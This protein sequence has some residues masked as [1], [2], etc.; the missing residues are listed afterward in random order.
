MASLDDFVDEISSLIESSLDFDNEVDEIMEDTARDIIE[1]IK[2]NAPIG[3]SKEHL[4]DSFTYLK[5]G[6]K[7]HKSITI[8]FSSKGRLVHLIEFGFI[9]RSG[10]FVNARPFLRPAYDKN[11]PKM[12]TKIKE[13]IKNATRKS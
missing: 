3:K 5:E 1:D 12:E 9:H 10:K 8:Y 6:T 2:S 7:V 11:E 13:A 4:K